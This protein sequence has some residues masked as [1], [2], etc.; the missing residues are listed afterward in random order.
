MR[1]AHPVLGFWRTAVVGPRGWLLGPGQTRPVPLPDDDIA[2]TIGAR[3]VPCVLDL[4][5]DA[6]GRDQPTRVR[7]RLAFALAASAVPGTVLYIDRREGQARPGERELGVLAQLARLLVRHPPESPTEETGP[8][9]FPGIIGRSPAMQQLFEQMTRA[10][11]SDLD[12]H[13]YGE[14][15][16]GKEE[17]AGALHRH[18][19]RRAGPYVAFN[20]SA[21][22][23]ELFESELFG[24]VKG[25]FTGAIA[26]RSG[27]VAEAEGGTLFI[28]EVAELSGRAQTRLLRFLQEREYRRVGET[29]LRRADIRVV[30]A[31]NADLRGQVAAGRFR[32]DLMYRLDVA[33]LALPPLRERGDDVPRL[34]RH[35]L[36]QAA[37][38][39][40]RRAPVLPPDVASALRSYA[41]P[42]NVREL[43]NEMK[44]LVLLAGD[45][46]IRMEQVSLDLAARPSRGTLRAARHA[47]AREQVSG[48]LA[49]NGGSRVRTAQELGITRQAL[50]GMM[51]RLGL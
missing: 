34:A 20:A 47:F 1:A 27:Y 31:T 26:A 2:W 21:L 39:A 33:R 14:T 3:A 7:H 19:R 35:F 44:R 43:D 11:A 8:P 5:A 45:G 41:W 42:G 17:V 23:D 25:A 9:T 13:V 49:R 32:Q 12:V 4:R 18:S 6:E 16:T 36:A 28:D 37:T 22:S 40:G 46:P 38:R 48:A 51:R 30:T 24:H 50:H 29:G 10:A 15:G